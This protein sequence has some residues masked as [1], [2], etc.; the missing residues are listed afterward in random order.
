ME[1]V[2]KSSTSTDPLVEVVENIH[3]SMLLAYGKKYT[4]MWAGSTAD[5]IINF[6]V[7]GLRGYTP[8]EVKRGIDAGMACD[9]PPT[10]PQFQKL[11]RPPVS[12]TAAY[13]EA[14]A[15]LVAR[16]KG[17]FGDWSSPAVFWAASHLKVELMSQSYTQI[18]DR[19]NALLKSQIERG[20]WAEIPMARVLL[21]APEASPNA[22]QHAD[23][24]VKKLG[25]AGVL[26]KSGRDPLAWA[27]RIMERVERGDKSLA[28][29]QIKF[30]KMALGIKDEVTA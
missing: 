24:M 12:E 5:Q 25:A 14:M 27:K 21:P 13:Y 11:C 22:R 2:N 28:M 10:L 29:V 26:D 30:A 17:E 16:A 20:Q 6:W 1:L 7:T 4:D 8:R 15:G 23:E 3:A 19:W 18:K 9:W